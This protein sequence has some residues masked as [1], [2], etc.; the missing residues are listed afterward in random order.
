MQLVFLR[1][2]TYSETD[3]IEKINPHLTKANLKAVPKGA[4]C[5]TRQPWETCSDYLS[6]FSGLTF[7][8]DTTNGFTFIGTTDRGLNVDCKDFKD[9]SATSTVWKAAYD[10]VVLPES[11]G[12]LPGQS[13]PVPK[14]TPTFFKVQLDSS[15]GKLSVGQF[16]NLKKTNGV[17]V[18]G[19]SN[20]LGIDPYPYRATC[21]S[22]PMGFNQGGLDVEDIQIVYGRDHLAI[23]D[24]YG[25]SIAIVKG[26]G[27]GTSCGEV[28][29][30]YVPTD[31]TLRAKKTGY[32]I[33]KV[34]PAVFGTR[35]MNRGFENL[36]I[37][38]DGKS[39]IAII[40]SP[41]VRL[42]DSLVERICNPATMCC[43]SRIF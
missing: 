4:A 27:A 36:A 26:F 31:S 42:Y 40:Q 5:A 33:F 34:L 41:L 23:V 29:A 24:E 30:R 37:S 1:S 6:L 18:N 28:V 2:A 8:A 39:V 17:R 43:S 15:T 32:P 14:F 20:V 38:A 13:F 35:R 10:T 7:E 21:A 12:A 11:N 19:L 9:F 22:G 16:C 3:A 25:P